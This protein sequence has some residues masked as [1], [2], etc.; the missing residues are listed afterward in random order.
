MPVREMYVV[1]LRERGLLLVEPKSGMS[2]GETVK[3]ALNV[4]G[5]YSAGRVE[6]DIPDAATEGW[7]AWVEGEGPDGKPYFF[8]RA[9]DAALTEADV[10]AMLAQTNETPLRLNRSEIYRATDERP[11]SDPGV[12]HVR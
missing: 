11:N 1:L 12:I 4:D 10:E 3:S 5:G 7:V 2:Q 9:F 6:V 8:F